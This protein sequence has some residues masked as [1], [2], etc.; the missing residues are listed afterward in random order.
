MQQYERSNIEAQQR[1]SAAIA[2]ASST[3]RVLVDRRLYRPSTQYPVSGTAAKSLPAA[4]ARQPQHGSQTPPFATA[5]RDILTDQCTTR[6]QEDVMTNETP[7]P[8]NISPTARSRARVPARAAAAA[9]ARNTTQATRIA[10]AHRSAAQ[11]AASLM[12]ERVRM[13]ASR[14]W[15]SA[16]N[17]AMPQTDWLAA[18]E[19]DLMAWLRAGGFAAVNDAS[20]AAGDRP[21]KTAA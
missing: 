8:P 2:R 17:P 3:R 16:L 7:R 11:L 6:L 14:S 18:T 19:E 21:T 9:T 4:A 12:L 15:E 13:R 20:R 10:L 5:V 1:T